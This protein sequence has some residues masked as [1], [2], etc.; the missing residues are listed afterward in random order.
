VKLE[1]V[2]LG[3]G[4]AAG[5]VAR[6][7]LSSSFDALGL[8]QLRPLLEASG[9][10][11]LVLDDDDVVAFASSAAASLLCASSSAIERRPLR[12]HAALA[13]PGLP[14]LCKRV[15][16]CVASRWRRGTDGVSWPRSTCC[17]IDAALRRTCR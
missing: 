13:T 17:M 14:L 15:T 7:E 1:G 2:V 4:S 12:E 9:H 5:G 10:A 3:I 6:H 16:A 8:V 11:L